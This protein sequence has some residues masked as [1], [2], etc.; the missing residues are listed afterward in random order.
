MLV[1][2]LDLGNRLM[3]KTCSADWDTYIKMTKVFVALDDEQHFHFKS[4]KWPVI[5]L[6]FY[7]PNFSL[8]SS[9]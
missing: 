1:G 6:P 2:K 7:S 5:W 4:L 3:W 8:Q 9:I